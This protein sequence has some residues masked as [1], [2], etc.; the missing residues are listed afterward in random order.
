MWNDS[1]RSH[2]STVQA[3]RELLSA[4]EWSR[5]SRALMLP[6]LE[7]FTYLSSPRADEASQGWV[8]PDDHDPPLA[9]SPC[10]AYVSVVPVGVSLSSTPH[11]PP[12]AR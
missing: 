10:S 1:N 2:C 6:V 3:K 8:D 9:D 11:A 4:V 7:D 12:P 5:E